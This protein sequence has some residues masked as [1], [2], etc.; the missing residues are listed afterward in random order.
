MTAT[1]GHSETL[2][3]SLIPLVAAARDW[4][5]ALQKSLLRFG[6]L[7]G[8]R[9][10]GALR[11]TLK[12]DH[13][14]TM[15]PF[16]EVLPAQQFSKKT[17]DAVQECLLDWMLQ[18]QEPIGR[19]ASV[20]LPGQQI[21]VFAVRAEDQVQDWIIAEWHDEESV[22]PH[23]RAEFL[24][25][26]MFLTAQLSIFNR[27]AQAEQLLHR[28]DL[29]GLY[30]HRFLDASL[31][32]EIK[33]TQRFQTSFC[34]LFIDLDNFKPINDEHGHMSGSGVLRQ[35]AD[36]LRDSLREVDTI[37]RYGGDEFV[38]VLLET[39]AQTGALAAERIRRRI[40]QHPFA[41]EGGQVVK[42]TC[43][44]GVVACPEHGEDHGALL[45]AADVC[46]YKSK[47]TGKNQVFVAEP[48]ARNVEALPKNAQRRINP[49]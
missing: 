29:T 26:C 44:I 41:T 21:Q 30:N 24:Q 6:E 1:Q 8:M 16:G 40:A 9:H 34:I 28:D 47:R 10:L 36:V 31:R 38:V 18:R 19:P 33:R 4:D 12:K 32:Q 15:A 11:C 14:P 48:V 23:S 22:S 37:F 43:S 25:S 17:W 46:M 7:E 27:L 2:L 13:P 5:E 3:L 45:N 35:V 42:I 49:S 20:I 39:T